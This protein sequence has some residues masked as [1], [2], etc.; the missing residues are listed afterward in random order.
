MRKK[1]LIRHIPDERNRQVRGE[2]RL[3]RGGREGG[4]GDG[5]GWV[6]GAE[7]GGWKKG[8]RRGGSQ[9][10]AVARAEVAAEPLYAPLCLPRQRR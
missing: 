3:R 9:L 4:E 5:G 6:K 2:G 8:G 7:R 10:E 1:I